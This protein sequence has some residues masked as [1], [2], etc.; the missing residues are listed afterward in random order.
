MVRIEAVA[1][2][3]A[4]AGEVWRAVSDYAHWPEWA[5]RDGGVRL[6]RVEPGV[7]ALDRVGAWRRCTATLPHL[8]AWGPPGGHEVTW[9]EIVSDVRAPWVLELE[10]PTIGRLIRRWR[11]RLTMVEQPDGRTRVRCRLSYRAGSVLAWLVDRLLVR[12]AIAAGVAAALSGLTQSFAADLAVAG[13]AVAADATQ[14][15]SQHGDGPVSGRELLPDAGHAG[16]PSLA[17]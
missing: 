12:R 1:I 13:L 11:L 5:A 7:G 6:A 8:I 3:P 4:R 9:T 14:A 15:G 17:A 10:A 16:Q 2:V